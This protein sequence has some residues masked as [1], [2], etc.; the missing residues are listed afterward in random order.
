MRAFFRACAWLPAYLAATAAGIIILGVTGLTLVEVFGRTFFG[1]S[2]LMAE[3]AGGFG[4]VGI[5]FLGLAYTLDTG[6]HTRFT[7]VLSRLGPR[8]REFLERASALVGLLFLLY[9]LPQA[10]RFVSISFARDLRSNSI[11][12]LPLVWPQA[13]LFL[14]LALMALQ[15]LVRLVRGR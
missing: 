10:W 13:L 7:V 4:M 12:R 1:W 9:L 14:G 2:T 6:R 3:D 5:I 11:A 15:W 8:Q